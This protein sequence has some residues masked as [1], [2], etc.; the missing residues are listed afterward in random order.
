VYETYPSG[1]SK[2]SLPLIPSKTY[3]FL[4]NKIFKIKK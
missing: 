4:A 1:N 3:H 2:E